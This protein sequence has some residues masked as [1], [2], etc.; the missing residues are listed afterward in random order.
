[1]LKRIVIDN[2]PKNVLYC[3]SC[4]K[5]LSDEGYHCT[6]CE[7]CVESFYRHSFV[8]NN[9][10]GRDNVKA[11]LAQLLTGALSYAAMIGWIYTS[12]DFRPAEAISEM[13]VLLISMSFLT[14]YTYS[15]IEELIVIAR[16]NSAR[17]M[18]LIT[19]PTA[20]EE[21]SKSGWRNLRDFF[22]RSGKQSNGAE[23]VRRFES[24]III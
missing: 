7:V 18:K 12:T 20:E 13:L 17:G 3:R 11:Y 22:F 6:H 14:N 24:S 8:L 9:C 5:F 2:Q 16:G 23:L 15:F 1:M 4:S 19:Q 10:I 21:R